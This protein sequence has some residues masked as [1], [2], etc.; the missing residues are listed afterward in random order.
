[1]R[2]NSSSENDK[3]HEQQQNKVNAP[4]TVSQNG[5]T[6]ESVNVAHTG[7]QNFA[8][9][10]ESVAKPKN[11]EREKDSKENDT[12]QSKK[13][14]SSED[15]DEAEELTRSVSEEIRKT[16]RDKSS[17]NESRGGFGQMNSG[18]RETFIAPSDAV[19]ARAILHIADLERIVSAIRTKIQAGSQSE[20]L[21]ELKNSVLEGLKI[22]LS[23]NAENNKVSAEFIAA[24]ERVKSQ[25]D[26]RL[27]DLSDLLRSRG[28][29]LAELKTSLSSNQFGDSN[30]DSDNRDFADNKV[31]SSVNQLNIE[32]E[33][34]NTTLS[35]EDVIGATY[36]A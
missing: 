31:L 30:S 32:N 8:N 36:R 24:T 12:T 5:E 3:Q 4:R 10:L 2:I 11:K 29:T 28:I 23:A 13:T 21:I 22:R 25:L 6:T 16:K 20:V 14:D 18:V 7:S 15:S 33:I 17:D 26:A 35:D 9:I 27:T 19:S 34:T 1:M